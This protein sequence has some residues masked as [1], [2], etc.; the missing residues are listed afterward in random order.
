MTYD[1]IGNQLTIRDPNR[2]G[3]DMVYDAHN[4]NTQRTDTFSDV[5]KTEYTI[6]GEF[7]ISTSIRLS[8]AEGGCKGIR[9]RNFCGSLNIEG[10]I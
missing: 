10:G 2:V 3:A 6:Q 4:R 8:V 9:R 5:I 7:K 1:A